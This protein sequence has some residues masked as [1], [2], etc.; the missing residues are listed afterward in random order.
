VE[1]DWQSAIAAL[2]FVV[3]WVTVGAWQSGNTLHATPFAPPPVPAAEALVVVKSA[4]ATPKLAGAMNAIAA[5]VTAAPVQ[6]ESQLPAGIQA[7]TGVVTGLLRSSTGLLLAEIRIAVTPVDESIG[8]GALESNG[9]TGLTD[10]AGRYR[11]EGI[12]PGRYYILIGVNGR[13]FYYPGVTDPGQAT[14]IQVTAGTTTEVSDTV[15]TGGPVMGRVIAT[16]SGHHLENLFLCCDYFKELRYGPNG[17]KQGSPFTPT[18]SADGSFVFPFVPT[19][20][21]AMSILDRG[22]TGHQNEFP[23]SWAL[24][25]GPNGV[26]GLQLNVV[27]GVEVQGTVLDQIGKPVSADVRLVSRPAKSIFTTIGQA[28]STGV[29]P[30]LSEIGTPQRNRLVLRGILVPKAYPSLDEIQ[31]VILEAARNRERTATPDRLASPEPDGKF[32]IHNVYPGTYALEVNAKGVVLPVREIEVGIAGL[33]NVSIQVPAIQVTGRVI[34]PRGGPLPKL[35]YIR[36]VRTA[37]DAD[38][39]YGFPDTEGHFSLVLVP[40]EYRVFTESLGPAVQSVSDG[41]Q[42]ITNTEFKLEDGRNS[43]L[44]VTLI[45]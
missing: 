23:L 20:N 3:V 24:A 45:P 22:L 21:Y 37:S 34:A 29:R 15:V 11:L 14:A 33:T 8:I 18:I 2:L 44:V 12:S 36:V 17:L 40:G 10:F 43:Q 26:T 30:S 27:E 35:N 13:R 41:L 31:D 39:F 32:A 19:G 25:V 1:H 9:L 28:M 16:G 4:A 42:D 7:R 6:P 38:V 5:I